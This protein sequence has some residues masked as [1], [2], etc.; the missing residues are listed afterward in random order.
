VCGELLI[1]GKSVIRHTQGKVAGRVN[2]EAEGGYPAS[3]RSGGA[4]VKVSASS[5]RTDVELSPGDSNISSNPNARAST[6]ARDMATGPRLQQQD[7]R[8]A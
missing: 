4:V 1:L 5:D 8:S 6:P 3:S 7:D 2:L